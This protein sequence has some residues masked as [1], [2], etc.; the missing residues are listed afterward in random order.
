MWRS[1]LGMAS[2]LQEASQQEDSRASR[3]P[4]IVSRYTSNRWTMQVPHSPKTPHQSKSQVQLPSGRGCL[5][6]SFVSLPLK[7]NVSGRSRSPAAYSADS[8]PS[9]STNPSAFL[10]IN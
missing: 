7:D 2:I 8:S 9:P 6:F 5:H 10:R 4:N 3:T 1:N